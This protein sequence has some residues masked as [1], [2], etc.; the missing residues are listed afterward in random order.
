MSPKEKDYTG[1]RILL[2]GDSRAIG[3]HR[4]LKKKYER[5]EDLWLPTP[6]PEQSLHEIIFLSKKKVSLR[7]SNTCILTETDAIQVHHKL[8][9]SAAPGYIL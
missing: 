5:C 7:M 8:D 2:H 3:V 6:K 4:D 1:K 9:L